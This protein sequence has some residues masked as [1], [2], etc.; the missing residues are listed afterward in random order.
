MRLTALGSVCFVAGV[1]LARRSNPKVLIAG[2]CEGLACEKNATLMKVLFLGEIG[3][4]QT[5]L[6]RMRAFERL[7]HTVRGVHTLNPWTRVSWLKRR[8]QRRMQRGSVIDEVNDSVVRS[9]REFGPHVVWAEKQEFLRRETIEELRKVGART[10]HFT[11]DPYFS[12]DWKRTR[13]MDEAMGD[14]RC[15]GLL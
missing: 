4:G 5:S 14:I 15:P 10:V 7:G 6:M 8:V 12:L 3:P 11:P 9:A 1:W 2:V 13:L